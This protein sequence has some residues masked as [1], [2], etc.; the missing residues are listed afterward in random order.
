MTPALPG[1]QNPYKGTPPRGWIRVR[2]HAVDGAVYE[3]ELIA[4]TGCPY[5]A[6]LG[7]V[8]LLRCKLTEAA[9]E[10]TVYGQLEGAWLRMSIP[11]VGLDRQ[12]I[13]YASDVVAQVTQDSHPD[14]TGLVGL[15]LLRLMDYGG[16]AD[17]FW[18]RPAG[19]AP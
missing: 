12:L 16:D 13:G 2:L 3:V 15:P 5:Y 19:S 17:W 14:F 8:D 18:I 7:S 4:D 11:E 10:D 9:P 6:V 1:Q